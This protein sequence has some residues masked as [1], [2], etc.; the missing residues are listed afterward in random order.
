[1]NNR[2]ESYIRSQSVTTYYIRDGGGTKG[3][4]SS[5]A[6]Y[7]A[8]AYSLIH[9]KPRV[10]TQKY[11]DKLRNRLASYL[12]FIDW[13]NR[14]VSRHS[15]RCTV[16]DSADCYDCTLNRWCYLGGPKYNEPR[17]W[18]TEARFQKESP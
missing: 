10:A 1:M 8:L 15:M 2:G 11:L 18:P 17:P 14:S 5:E 9:E 6:A 13:R 4:K 16:A 3:Y 7:K 12:D